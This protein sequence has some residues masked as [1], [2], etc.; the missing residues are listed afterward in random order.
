M[1]RLMRRIA[2]QGLEE[3]SWHRLLDALRDKELTLPDLLKAKNEGRLDALRIMVQ[4]PLLSAEE[5][6]PS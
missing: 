5:R 1:K 6:R 2:E 4:D 3:P